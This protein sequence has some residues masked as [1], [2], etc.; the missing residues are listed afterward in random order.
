M[1]SKQAEFVRNENIRNYRQQL[2]TEADPN[3][4][5]MLSRLLAQELSQLYPG[6]GQGSA[7]GDRAAPPADRH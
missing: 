1:T 6:P 4:R 3:K 7:P 5:E 2:R